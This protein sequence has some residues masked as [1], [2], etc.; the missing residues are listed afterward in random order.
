MRHISFLIKPA[1]GNCNLAC[2]YCFYIDEM[3]KRSNTFT[4]IMSKDLVDVFLQK[5]F[6]EKEIESVSFLF[7]GGEPLLVG[8]DFYEYFIQKVDTYNTQKMKVYYSLQTN[9]TLLDENYCKFFKK[10]H[11]LI[12]VSLD[13][14]KKVHD[15][16][17]TYK[18]GNKTFNIVFDKIKLLKQFD[19]P[20]NILVVIH[21]KTVLYLKE[22]MQFFDQQDFQYLQY[23]PCLNPYLDDTI[24]D[25]TLT[26]EDYLQFLNV[27]FEDYYQKMMNNQ[28]LYNRLF[29]NY[30]GLLLNKFPESCNMVGHCTNQFVIEANGS[31]Y[32][33]DFYALDKFCL[34]NIYHNSIESLFNNNIVQNFIEESMKK[35]SKCTTCKYKKL[36]RGGCKRE[37]DSN[38]LNQ[39]CKANYAFFEKNIQ[40]LFELANKYMK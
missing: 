16:F 8:L 18:N 24:Y 21:A 40:K 9:G 36:C 30:I 13:G 3:N 33:C 15:A 12:G 2:K 17:R 39:Y 26:N 34:G 1:S 38:G 27:C 37:R 6:A 11:F 23:I 5:V 35:P 28:Y 29:E 22:I 14:T 7:Q 20:F 4:K 31:V 25:Y 32:P 10:Y 19:V